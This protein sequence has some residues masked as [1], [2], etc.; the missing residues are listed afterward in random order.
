MIATSGFLTAL[1]CTRPPSWFKGDLFLRGRGAKG[2]EEGR[3]GKGRREKGKRRGK[4]GKGRGRPPY[5]KFLDPP[6]LR[7]ANDE[8]KPITTFM[9][10]AY[11]E[12]VAKIGQS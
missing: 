8:T 5:R 11:A 4:G 10:T 6:L 2:E 9:S 12:K 1:E 3:E 7:V